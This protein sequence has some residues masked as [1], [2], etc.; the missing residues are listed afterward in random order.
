MQRVYRLQV[1]REPFPA[2]VIA[3]GH[4][5]AHLEL[6]NVVVAVK[7]WRDQWA[8]HR[9]QIFCD[10]TNA[11]CAVQ[12]GR[13]RDVFVQECIRELFFFC[14]VF[15]I[16]LHLLH[17]PGRTLVRADALSRAHTA[18][19]FT[20]AVRDDPVLALMERVVVPEGYFDLENRL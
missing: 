12:T 13:S 1:L 14:A 16:Q 19:R 18:A 2:C 6:L 4:C 10:N 9:V 7:V 3:A 8:G 5:I 17:R 20:E 15:D 11:C